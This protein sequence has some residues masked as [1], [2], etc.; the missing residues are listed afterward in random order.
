MWTTI[1]ILCA[2]APSYWA[3]YKFQG[4]KHGWIF[5][6]LVALIIFLF[7]PKLISIL[8]YSVEQPRLIDEIN[9]YKIYKSPAGSMMIARISSPLGILLGIRKSKSEK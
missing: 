4:K 7:A 6:F 1:A 5:M 9:G 2:F 3:G 8:Y